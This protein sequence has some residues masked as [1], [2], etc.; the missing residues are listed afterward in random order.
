MGRGKKQ[1][2]NIPFN[3]LYTTKTQ[4]VAREERKHSGISP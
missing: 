1:T 4:A 2:F 3:T